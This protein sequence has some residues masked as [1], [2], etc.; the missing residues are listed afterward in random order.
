MFEDEATQ[1]FADVFGVEVVEDGAAVLA[2]HSWAP[3]SIQAWNW[4]CSPHQAATP[5]VGQWPYWAPKWRLVGPFSSLSLAAASTWGERRR[6]PPRPVSLNL[7]QNGHV[8]QVGR[9][10]VGLAL[11]SHRTRYRPTSRRSTDLHHAR[12]WR[13]L[14]SLRRRCPGCSRRG[15]R[16]LD[17]AF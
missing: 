9:F 4:G 5:V 12:S 16:S 3:C 14:L 10:I 15:W 8:S 7:S 2:G 17:R 6:H 13:T 1:M 11:E